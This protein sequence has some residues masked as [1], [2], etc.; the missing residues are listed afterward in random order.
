MPRDVRAK[1]SDAADLCL[2][3][4]EVA[5]RAIWPDVRRAD[6]IEAAIMTADPQVC[7]QYCAER[8]RRPKAN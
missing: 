8:L 4:V 7:A 6:A 5:M 3:A 2:K 1:V